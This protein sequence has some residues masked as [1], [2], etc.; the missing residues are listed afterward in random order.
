[1]YHGEILE[2]HQDTHFLMPAKCISI[3]FKFLKGCWFFLPLLVL[4]WEKL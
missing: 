3:F 4:L 1:M 2:V